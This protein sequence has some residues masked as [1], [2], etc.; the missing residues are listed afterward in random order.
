[1]D[2]QV[3]PFLYADFSFF[4]NPKRFFIKKSGG[5]GCGR[6]KYRV[7]IE[8]YSETISMLFT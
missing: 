3:F 7:L 5:H 2:M 8:I 4:Y 6:R 1:M